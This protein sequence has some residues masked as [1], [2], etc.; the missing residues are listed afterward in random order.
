MIATRLFSDRK[1]G[2]C[3][4]DLERRVLEQNDECIRLCGDRRGSVCEKGCMS[5][6]RSSSAAPSLSEGIRLSRSLAPAG[7]NLC[8]AAIVNDGERITTLLYAIERRS[9]QELALA[10]EAP[11]SAREREIISLVSSGVSN[12]DVARR[13]FISKATLRTHLNNI[14]KKLPEEL[15]LSLSRWRSRI[16]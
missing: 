2:I 7:S 6:Y 12:E 3:V 9:R 16:G 14:Y 10:A 15:R 11:L 4:K 5:G 8:E 1:I 13:L